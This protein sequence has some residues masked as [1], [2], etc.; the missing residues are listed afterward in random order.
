MLLSKINVFNFFREISNSFPLQ[1]DNKVC[2]L[3]KKPN[4]LKFSYKLN[5]M[6]VQFMVNEIILN[7]NKDK[8]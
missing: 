3:D 8:L 1:G 5:N 4:I 2:I 7:V 6:N